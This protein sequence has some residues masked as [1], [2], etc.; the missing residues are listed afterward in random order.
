MDLGARV[1]PNTRV[2]RINASGPRATSVD[3][4]DQSSGAPST[5]HA[6]HVVLAAGALGSPHLL[7]SSGI[8]GEG[9]GA[10]LTGRFLF[11]HINCVA[12][13][14]LPTRTNPR[15]EFHKQ[16]VIPDYYLGDP[17]GR[18]KPDGPWGMIQQVHMPG[19]GVLMAESPRGWKT[20]TGLARPHLLGLLC[21][22]ED[23][24]QA[25]NRVYADSATSDR[26]GQPS[27]KVF[28]RYLPRDY[29]SVEALAR[30]ARK[31]LRR[32][33]ALPV[34]THSISSFSHALG[35][36]RFGKDRE[37]SVLDPE[38]RVWGFENLYVVDGSFMPSGG[39]VNPSLTI[40]ANA[41]RVGA[42][43]AGR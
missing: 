5:I 30:V 8:R 41:L 2:V 42:I 9:S 20:L 40:G 29:R 18:E 6:A 24:P 36:C 32:A 38:C 22:A 4:L 7:L 43:L 27:Q 39:A 34:H 16:V 37:T 11:R 21:I 26:F 13:G 15:N 1:V 35:T 10:D 14:L 25:S 12:A 17:S 23:I 33:M 19:K 28:H 31:V 3:I